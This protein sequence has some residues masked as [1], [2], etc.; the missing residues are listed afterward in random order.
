MNMKIAQINQCFNTYIQHCEKFLEIM[1]LFQLP[2]IENN[3]SSVNLKQH[4]ATAVADNWRILDSNSNWVQL[5]FL[6]SLYIK[7]L[8]PKINDGLKA[9]KELLFQ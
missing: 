4:I 2:G 3:N 9:S 5:C 7:R 6:E 8:K 1:T